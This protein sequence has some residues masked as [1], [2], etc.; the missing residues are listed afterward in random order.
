MLWHAV[1]EARC[2]EGVVSDSKGDKVPQSVL[3]DWRKEFDFSLIKLKLDETEQQRQNLQ[4]LIAVSDARQDLLDLALKRM[5]HLQTQGV[6][7]C[8]WDTRW[9][10]DDNEIQLGLENGTLLKSYSAGGLSGSHDSQSP[11]LAS[12]ATWWCSDGRECSR[13]Q[14]WIKVLQEDLELERTDLVSLITGKPGKPKAEDNRT[15]P[16]GTLRNVNAKFASGWIIQTRRP[17]QQQ[18]T[19]ALRKSQPRQSSRPPKGA[20]ARRL[21]CEESSCRSEYP[22]NRNHVHLTLHRL[23]SRLCNCGGNDF[24]HCAGQ[25]INIHPPP[26]LLS[27]SHVLRREPLPCVTRGTFVRR[28]LFGRRGA[29]A[30]QSPPAKAVHLPCRDPVLLVSI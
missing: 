2:P 12:L 18:R 16:S 29:S 27:R 20:I 23:L 30:R 4:R 21:M 10:W 7:E 25:L 14:G 24:P 3:W 1:K 22:C 5:Q 11:E 8:G 13:H 28:S 6:M 26:H 19:A 9:L 17:R 15:Q